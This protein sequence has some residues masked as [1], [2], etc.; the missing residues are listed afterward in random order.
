MKYKAF[1]LIELLIVCAIIGLMTVLTI[2]FFSR[3][4][5]RSEFNLRSIEVKSLIE[6]MGNM[7]KNPKQ[8][9]SRYVI[10]ADTIAKTIELHENDGTGELIKKI[11][12]PSS[13]AIAINGVAANNFLVCDTPADFCCKMP[14]TPTIGVCPNPPTINKFKD[15]Y[16]TITGGNAGD[17]GTASFKIDYEPFRVTVH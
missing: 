16:I 15:D 6:Q 9:I 10:K 14:A 12:L 11:T 17:D 2:P 4:G 1:T 7:A 3:Y 13:Y 8:G 5:A